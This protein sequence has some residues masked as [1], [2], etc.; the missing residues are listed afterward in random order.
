MRNCFCVRRILNTRG[1]LNS[2][3]ALASDRRQPLLEVRSGHWARCPVI[4]PANATT[5]FAGERDK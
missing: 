3:P 1:L 4:S 5:A 2:V